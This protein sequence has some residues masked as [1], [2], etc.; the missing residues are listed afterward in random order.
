VAAV[1]SG[2][3][4]R[5][6][7]RGKNPGRYRSGLIHWRPGGPIYSEIRSALYDQPKRPKV[8]G[9]I[10]GLGGRDVPPEEVVTMVERAAATRGKKKSEEFHLIGVR[11]RG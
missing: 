8:V 11:E 10:A 2:R 4:K 3:A 5:D 6:D 9:F 7:L 1:P